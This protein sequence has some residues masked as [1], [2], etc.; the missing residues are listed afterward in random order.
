M[1]RQYGW[2]SLLL[3]SLPVLLLICGN[4]AMAS[5]QLLFTEA[6][7]AIRSQDANL[8][9]VNLRILSDAETHTS[10]GPVPDPSLL[11]LYCLKDRTLYSNPG[12]LKA[13][14]DRFGP[15]AVRF[16]AAHELAHGRQH[17]VTGFSSALVWSEVLDE[18]QADCIAGTYLRRTYGLTPDSADTAG[19]LAFAETLGDYSYFA[20]GWHG[21]P[22]LRRKAVSRGLNQ[23]DPARCLSSQRFNYANLVERG[24]RWLPVLQRLLQP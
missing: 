9:A 16:L 8:E 3:R 20:R 10:C 7:E 14:T 6:Y 4:R 19:I 12:T 1:C 5:P 23:G 24:R 17:A 21:T 18:L 2:L 15:G 22:G 13:L 11:G